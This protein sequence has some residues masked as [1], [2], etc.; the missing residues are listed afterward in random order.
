MVARLWN[1]CLTPGVWL[2]YDVVLSEEEVDEF[3]EAQ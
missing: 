2:L 3:K 1:Y